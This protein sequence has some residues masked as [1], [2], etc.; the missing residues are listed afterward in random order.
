MTRL[1]CGGEQ[2][3][4]LDHVL[5]HKHLAF[6]RLSIHRISSILDPFSGPSSITSRKDHHCVAGKRANKKGRT[7]DSRVPDAIPEERMEEHV[8]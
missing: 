5:A 8:S 7:N 1:G 3:A 4:C 6:Y 2:L